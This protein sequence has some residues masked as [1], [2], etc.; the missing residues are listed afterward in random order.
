MLYSTQVDMLVS[1]LLGAYGVFVTIG[2]ISPEA[3]AHREREELFSGDSTS[4]GK[5]AKHNSNKRKTKKK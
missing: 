4:D 3:E 5:K 2:P 1:L